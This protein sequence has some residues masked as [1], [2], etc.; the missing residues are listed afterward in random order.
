VTELNDLVTNFEYELKDN[1][2]LLDPERLTRL[3]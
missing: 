2:Q 3:A 1:V